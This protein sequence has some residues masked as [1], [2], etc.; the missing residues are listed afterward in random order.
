[1]YRLIALVLPIVL[2]LAGGQALGQSDVIYTVRSVKVDVRAESAAKA[3]IKAISEAQVK[4][5]R[6]LVKRI[7]QEDALKRL[8]Y[9]KPSDIGRLMSSLSIEEERTGPGRY[10]GRLTI[11]F[12]PDRVRRL[13]ARSGVK[14][15]EAKAPKIIIL[16]LWKTDQGDILWED[17]PW[18]TAWQN[19]KAEDALV[20]VLVPLGDLA[21][22]QAISPAE[23]LAGDGVK[24]DVIRLRYDGQ[25]IL[26]AIA[27]ARGENSVHATMVGDSPVGQI[28]FDKTYA[29]T[30]GGIEEAA[31]EA[32]RR[33]HAVM[34]FKWKK[35][36]G[37]SG[38]AMLR[39]QVL[40]VAVPFNTLEQWNFIRQRLLNTPGVNGVDVSQLSSGGAVVKVKYGIGFQ[41]LQ[42]S[43]AQN[44]LNLTLIGGTWVL[45]PY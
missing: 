24:L 21:D 33:F 12:L 45:Q 30:E 26:V 5:F 4:A 1:M 9:L 22:A 20:P 10:I 43:L 16:P 13:L 19:L 18:R 25:A 31:A 7:G 29:A 2:L 37:D 27:E 17:N 35:I 6:T 38:S 41:D 8:S 3:K 23:A 42:S 39:K 44:R 15:T 28:L 36:Q 14:F 40:S 32:V 11:T 34:T